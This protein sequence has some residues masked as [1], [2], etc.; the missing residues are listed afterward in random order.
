MFLQHFNLDWQSVDV[1]NAPLSYALND[2]LAA[3]GTGGRW[4]VVAR[5]FAPGTDA[6]A[7]EQLANLSPGAPSLISCRLYSQHPIVTAELVFGSQE[8]AESVISTFSG[9][10][11]N[12]G[13]IS[14]A[15]GKE[16]EFVLRAP[17]P[18]AT[19][20]LSPEIV[21]KANVLRNVPLEDVVYAG[22]TMVQDAPAHAGGYVNGVWQNPQPA[23]QSSVET[24]A[25]A[26][27][28][29]GKGYVGYVGIV[30]FEENYLRLVAAM[31]HF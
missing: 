16:L 4:V 30:D 9:K 3:G 17:A 13:R 21:A 23:Q 6:K 15:E 27:A 10:S 14:T 19:S 29:V 25:A 8:G 28:K 26:Y 22:T 2:K 24:A 18:M 11:V 31:C 7:I 20:D 5:N 12:I 1:T